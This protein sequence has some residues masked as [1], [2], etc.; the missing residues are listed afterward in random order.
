MTKNDKRRRRDAARKA[1]VLAAKH[2]QDCRDAAHRGQVKGDAE[3]FRA[4]AKFICSLVLDA[5]GRL[6]K[7]GKDSDANAVRE[8]H[9]AI[10]GDTKNTEQRA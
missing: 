5:A 7:E 1:E 2:E 4:G 8:V 10:A 6:F 3:G 9:R